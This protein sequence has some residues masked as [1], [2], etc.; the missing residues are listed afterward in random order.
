MAKKKPYRF[1]LYLFLRFAA[2]I[3]SRMPHPCALRLARILGRLGYAVISRQRENALENL[4]FAYAG[5][6]NEAEIRAIA[7]KV[8]ENLAM[9]GAEVLQF[10]KLKWEQTAA[11]IDAGEAWQVYDSLLREG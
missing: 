6:K 11:R 7:K 2:A 10:P 3:F 8:F 1:V 9:T 4:R 5:E